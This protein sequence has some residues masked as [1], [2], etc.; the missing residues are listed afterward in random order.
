LG[1]ADSFERVGMIGVLRGVLWCPMVC[2]AVQ[3]SENRYMPTRKVQK[4]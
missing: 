1:H 2:I 4:Q 3:M